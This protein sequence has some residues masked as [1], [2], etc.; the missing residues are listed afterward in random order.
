MLNNKINLS[1]LFVIN[2]SKLTL[3]EWGHSSFR[4]EYNIQ[5]NIF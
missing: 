3:A 5:Q 1:N 4:E 2:S